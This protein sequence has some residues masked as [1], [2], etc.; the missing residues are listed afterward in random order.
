M[1][2]QY[3]PVIRIARER[4]CADDHAMPLGDRQA[5]LDAELIGL[6]CFALPDAF[7]LGRVQCESSAISDVRS[8]TVVLGRIPS[9]CG[10]I[11]VYSGNSCLLVLDDAFWAVSSWE[12][13]ERRLAGPAST[14]VTM[15]CSMRSVGGG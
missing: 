9:N 11:K 5:D 7:N 13:F 14:G 6:A 12:E 10:E 2:G 8:I 3:V 1:F 4:L 15:I